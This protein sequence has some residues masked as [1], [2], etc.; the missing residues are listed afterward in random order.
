MN[1]RNT[2][3][4]PLRFWGL[5]HGCC[6]QRLTHK[7]LFQLLAIVD[8]NGLSKAAV[9]LTVWLNLAG[10]TF[11]ETLASFAG[12]AQL[13]FTCVTTSFGVLKDVLVPAG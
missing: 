8:S 5:M 3:W 11:S 13:H 9:P 4:R 6:A 10:H 2:F 1:A 7:Q 12:R